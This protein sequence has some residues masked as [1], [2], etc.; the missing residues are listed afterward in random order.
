MAFAPSVVLLWP[1]AGGR[2]REIADPAPPS[3]S[4]R[5]GLSSTTI[6]EAV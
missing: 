4:F 6:E 2:P 3:V 5:H 1:Q